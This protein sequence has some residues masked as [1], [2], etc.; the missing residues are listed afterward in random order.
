MYLL[1]NDYTAAD[2]IPETRR[3]LPG[4]VVPWALPECFSIAALL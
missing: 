4:V 2:S 1:V 3:A